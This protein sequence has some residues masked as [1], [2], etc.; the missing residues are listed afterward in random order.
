MDVFIDYLF[1]L[2]RSFCLVSSL[3]FY[4]VSSLIDVCM[5]LNIGIGPAALKLFEYSSSVF[6]CPLQR[7]VAHC[8][9]AP[10]HRNIRG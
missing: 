4:S 5:Q 1:T 10:R 9:T 3:V 6:L 8:K 7:K 2:L